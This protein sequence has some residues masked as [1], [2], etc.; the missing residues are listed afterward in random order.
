MNLRA[1]GVTTQYTYEGGD[2]RL[3]ET[4]ESP[5]ANSL[6]KGLVR[7]AAP[8]FTSLCPITGQPDFATIK[9]DYVPSR[10]CVESKSLKLYLGSF[11]QTGMFHEACIEKICADLANLLNPKDMRVT[12]EFMPRGGISFWP[13]AQYPTPCHL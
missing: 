5:F 11:R 13:V 12:G 7:I 3:L 4:F 8:E 6:I 1:L 10:L 9:I 2:A